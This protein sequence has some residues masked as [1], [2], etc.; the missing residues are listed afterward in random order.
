MI[1]SRTT[2][3]CFGDKSHPL[4]TRLNCLLPNHT[5]LISLFLSLDALE[6]A[7]EAH[8]EFLRSIAQKEAADPIGM[9]PVNSTATGNTST[10]QHHPPQ[11][12]TPPEAAPA[13]DSAYPAPASTTRGTRFW[14]RPRTPAPP[15]A[16]FTSPVPTRRMDMPSFS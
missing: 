10:S 5:K 4:S 7:E 12:G 6:A 2:Q 9:A 3:F 14:N 8:S 13:N 1:S 16:S 15:G 11:Y